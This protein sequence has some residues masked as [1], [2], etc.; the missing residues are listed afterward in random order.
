MKKTYQ[1]GLQAE[2]LVKSF[3]QSNGYKIIAHRYK[4]RYG[5]VDIIAVKDSANYFTK[6]LSKNKNSGTIYFIEVKYRKNNELIESVLR[7]NQIS[8]IKDAA[9][10][11]ISENSKYSYH[12]ISFDF[13]TV[14][15]NSNIQIYQDFF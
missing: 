13:V 15:K 12:N 11:F 1:T 5:E 7:S 3:Y 14:D 2:E 10:V 6:F 4:C 9:L 8:R